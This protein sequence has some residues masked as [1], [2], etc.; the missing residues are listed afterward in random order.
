MPVI[1]LVFTL[2]MNILSNNTV[3]GFFHMWILQ[4]WEISMW[5]FTHSSLDYFWTDVANNFFFFIWVLL[6]LILSWDWKN[7]RIFYKHITKHFVF[8]LPHR[9]RVGFSSPNNDVMNS[10]NSVDC[11]FKPKCSRLWSCWFLKNQNTNCLNL[12]DHE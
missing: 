5:N 9:I 12:L 2:M 6:V 3:I 8:I 4:C 7:G 11:W 1:K 10:S